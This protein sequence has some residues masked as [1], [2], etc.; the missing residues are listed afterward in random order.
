MSPPLQK[1]YS[2]LPAVWAS[3]PRILLSKRP[4]VTEVRDPPELRASV[5][6]VV[7]SRAKIAR[8]A[9]SC[10]FP[11][12][13]AVPVTYPHVIAMPLHLAIFANPAFQLGPMG[14][15]HVSNVIET[16]APLAAGARA[17][18]EVVARN[19]RRLDAG[20]AFDMATELSTGGGIA[21]RETCCF[22]ARWP[23]P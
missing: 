17:D 3:Y 22:M 9:T 18:V 10:G 11:A 7:L 19:Y 6:N 21:W 2:K 4:T 8:Y 14:L 1:V 15:I 16:L 13:T 5:R 20:L 23:T 12:D